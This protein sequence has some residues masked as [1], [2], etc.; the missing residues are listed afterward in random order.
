MSGADGEGSL[1]AWWRSAWPHLAAAV[2]VMSLMLWP[3][4]GVVPIFDGWSFARCA[5]DAPGIAVRC[6]GHPTSG[7]GIVMAISKLVTLPGATALFLPSLVFG[8]IALAGLDRLAV[9]VLGVDARGERAML[10][11]TFALHP[12]ILSTVLQP[13]LDLALTA[14]TFWMFAG[15]T[16][17]RL[18]EVTLFGGL[19]IF[20]K[21][22]GLLLYGAAGLVL[23]LQALGRR[24]G[25]RTVVV[26]TV[27][28]L[29]F[30]GFL[31]LP[32][33]EPMY[34][35][36]GKVATASN[37]HP[38]DLWNR[39]L[40]NYGVLVGVLDFQWVVVL[41]AIVA[42]GAAIRAE[43]ARTFRG[44]G[45]LTQPRV[46]L[47]WTVAIGFVLMT[48]YRSFGNV[49][50]FVFL[51]P[52]LPLTLF[53]AARAGRVPPHLPIGFVALWAGLLLTASR[54][55]A[56][57]VMTAV[58]GRF[59]TGSGT[60][61]DMTRVSRECCG[62][63]RDQLVYNLQYTDFARAMDSAMVRIS[64]GRGVVVTMSKYAHWHAVTPVDAVSSRRA[65][66]GGVDVPLQYSESLASGEESVAHSWL[67][68][69]PITGSV[70]E[71][72]TGRYEIRDAGTVSSGGVTLRLAELTRRV[73]GAK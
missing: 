63:G 46:R 53:A 64:A 45:D 17:G 6:E 47:A 55:S 48:S 9:S 21:E 68:E 41:G 62:R 52:M 70:R 11:L 25:V 49:R 8:A 50:Y 23:W 4:R 7:W 30:A 5:L 1:G 59:S 22:T 43:G 36:G 67:I 19:L 33:P 12:A 20:S 73:E 35:G 13:N 38:F 57:P 51:L 66:V 39:Q 27:P 72:L 42:C 40:L 14:W 26:L 28:L 18:V 54:S 58:A 29:L 37:F 3:D 32:Q 31:M 15:V 2:I 71:S 56:D 60:M 69:W 16:R 24:E 65:L 44:W 10:A 34:F 61:Y